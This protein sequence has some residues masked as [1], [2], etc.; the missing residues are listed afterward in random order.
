MTKICKYYFF[1]SL[2]TAVLNSDV[3][4]PELKNSSVF[5]CPVTDVTGNRM[6]FRVFQVH[7]DSWGESGELFTRRSNQQTT[8][9]ISKI[10]ED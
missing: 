4:N 1:Q 3:Q 7:N 9:N 8:T 10:L 5:R 2:L 6:I